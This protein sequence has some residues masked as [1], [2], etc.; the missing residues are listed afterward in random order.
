VPDRVLCDHLALER[1]ILLQAPLAVGQTLAPVAR[2]LLGRGCAFGVERLLS[3]A[4]DAAPIARGAQPRGQLVPTRVAVELV[5][6]GVDPARLLDDLLGDLLIA[7]R[8]VM[9]R[10]RS[11]LRPIDRHDP[12]LHQARLGAQPQHAA[13]QLADP[14]LV[15]GAEPGDR[16]V[17]RHLISRDHPEGNVLA[18]APLDPPRRAHPHRVGVDQQRDHN[19]RLVRRAAHPSSR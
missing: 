2:N 7:A 3:L 5:L 8:R 17:V 4:Q 19:R 10:R 12:H 15:A 9:R 18:A 11:D 1:P 14:V 16:G 6:L 13:E